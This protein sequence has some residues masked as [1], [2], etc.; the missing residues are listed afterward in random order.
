MAKSL[1]AVN[2]TI[3]PGLTFSP[4]TITIHWAR[5]AESCSNFKGANYRD[6][7]LYPNRKKGYKKLTDETGE[8]TELNERPSNIKRQITNV[9]SK[10]SPKVLRNIALYHPN[11]SFIGMQQAILLG[12][13]FVRN[14]LPYDAVFV[15]PSLRTIMTAL[16]A[17]RG[18]NQRI[19]VI[20]FI[21]EH[22][23]IAGKF[24]NVNPPLALDKLKKYVAFVKD[25]LEENWIENFDD[26]ELMTLLNTINSTIKEIGLRTKESDIISAWNQGRKI[27]DCWRETNPCSSKP[28]PKDCQNNK[29]IV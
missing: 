3:K 26:I 1:P 18:T 19:I 4:K 17:F 25:W 27:F 22:L 16:L 2:M 28:V 10:I 23:N 15:S 13:D 20:P 24:D 8:V 12:T 21:V 11:L 14:Q 9:T 6:E 7:N 29:D 5:H